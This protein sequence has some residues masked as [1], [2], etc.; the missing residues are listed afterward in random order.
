[1]GSGY[2]SRALQHGLER[3][4]GRQRPER[5][6]AVARAERC[7]DRA[8]GVPVE[9]RA[10]QRD[11]HRLDEPARTRLV[12]LRELRLDD[13][14]VTRLELVEERLRSLQVAAQRAQHVEAWHVPAPLPDRVERALAKETRQHAV[15]DEPVAAEA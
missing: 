8:V 9:E 11:R 2:C 10:L 5:S 13:L 14:P 6:A 12:G 3:C 7:G 15:L 1:C 4:G